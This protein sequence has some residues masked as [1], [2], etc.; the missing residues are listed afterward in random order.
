VRLDGDAARRAAHGQAVAAEPPDGEPGEILLV[1]GDG[2]VA[3]AVQRDG[4]L[5]PVVGFRG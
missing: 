3:I 5:K 2:P 1:D 4:A